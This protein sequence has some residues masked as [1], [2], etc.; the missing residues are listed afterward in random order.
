MQARAPQRVGFTLIEILVVVAIIA[1]LIAVL[2]PSLANAR[3][4]AKQVV[5]LSNQK[6]FATA[7]FYYSQ[8]FKGL[9]PHRDDWLYTGG[10]NTVTNKANQP[11]PES[12][13][14][15]GRHMPGQPIRRA[16][17][18]QKE[19]FKCPLDDGSRNPNVSQIALLPAN[20]S[21]SRNLYIMQ[22]MQA[23]NLYTGSSDYFPI[24]KPKFPSRTPMMV[25]EMTVGPDA[26]SPLN[27]PEFW[28]SN[29]D[30]LTDR[31]QGRAV[32]SYHDM[33]AEMAN[34]RL[35]NRSFALAGPTAS[36][37]H[38]VMAPGIPWTR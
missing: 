9:L 23:A 13:V 3:R 4:T 28:I 33:H 27:D 1:L 17:I 18:T 11:L 35:Y 14:L 8:D 24:D 5:C 30:T 19:L 10:R 2:L 6:Q 32:L 36:Y 31:H 22:A 25:E 34:S 12:G 7:N 38:L 15:M 37:Q 26:M 16:Y 20:F 29:L 21:F